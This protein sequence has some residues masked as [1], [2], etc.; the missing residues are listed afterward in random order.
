MTLGSAIVDWSLAERERWPGG[1]PNAARIAEYFAPALRNGKPLGLTA[2]NWCAAGACFAAAQVLG[3]SD[4]DTVLGHGYRVSGL[5]LEQDATKAGVWLPVAQARA[6]ARPARGDLVILN[7]GAP[8]EWTKHVGRVIGVDSEGFDCIDA[9]GT[10]A[11]WALTRRPWTHAALRG[12]VRYPST[13]SS[14]SSA[15]GG[16]GLGLLLL[17]GATLFDGPIR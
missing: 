16:G 17:L 10:G 7:R 12:F 3:R 1:K 14:S 2:G 4:L 15:S 6:G 13:A 11:A 9:N 8:E 5:E